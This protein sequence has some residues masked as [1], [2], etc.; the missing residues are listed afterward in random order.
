MRLGDGV[1][2]PLEHL[3]QDAALV[4]HSQGEAIGEEPLNP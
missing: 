2:R 3:A 1:V 4:G